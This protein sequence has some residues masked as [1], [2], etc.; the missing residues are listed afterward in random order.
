[1]LL[2]VV[3]CSHAEPP[4]AAAANVAHP[5]IG[6]SLKAPPAAVEEPRTERV[7]AHDRPILDA[8]RAWGAS[9]PR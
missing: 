6:F 2:G 4:A 5:S 7:D 8:R 9:A 1:L 3:G